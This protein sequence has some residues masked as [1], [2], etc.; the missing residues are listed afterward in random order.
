MNYNFE[1]MDGL[2]VWF[3]DDALEHPLIDEYSMKFG[4]K[5]PELEGFFTPEELKK[6]PALEYSR[7]WIKSRDEKFNADCIEAIKKSL[8]NSKTFFENAPE[9]I[10]KEMI[11]EKKDLENGVLY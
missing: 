5:D 7:I 11:Q 4:E 3:N 1:Y 2:G 6:R 10:Q 9:Y 8:E